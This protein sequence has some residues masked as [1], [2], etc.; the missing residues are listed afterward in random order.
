MKTGEG[1]TLVATL[2][3]Y[4]NALSGNGVH[5][6]TVNDYL[7]RCGS[8]EMGRVY[9]FLGLTTGLIVH[10][11][12]P[13]EKRA[14]YESDITYATNNELGFDYLRDNMV[15]YKENMV[16]RGHNF[17][18]V[19][20]VDSILIDEARTPLIISGSGSK[21]TD[22][23][24]MAD[25]CARTFTKHVIKEIDA[26]SDNDVYEEDYIVDE[27]ARTAVLTK[28]GIQKVERFFNIENLSDP[29]NNAIYHHIYDFGTVGQIITIGNSEN[30]PVFKD[31]E[32][33]LQKNMP[34]GVVCD[35][36]IASGSYYAKC[37]HEMQKLLN[38]PELMEEPPTEVNTDF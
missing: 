34:L 4:L 5:I 7:A 20:E 14:A 23:Y 1:K 38:N 30:R 26:K 37:F 25:R 9:D 22:L 15:V 24:T 10:G 31:N 32:I 33:K 28:N 17:A 21:S 12:S 36:R 3:A 18:I 35:E 2:P 8:E 6:V 27:K 13:A 11:Q 16:Q 29:E 19:D